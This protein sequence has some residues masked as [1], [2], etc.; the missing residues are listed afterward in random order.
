MTPITTEGRNIFIT[1]IIIA[2]ERQPIRTGNEM[3]SCPSVGMKI[4]LMISADIIPIG[5]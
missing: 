5:T 4:C 2:V 1:F 3:P